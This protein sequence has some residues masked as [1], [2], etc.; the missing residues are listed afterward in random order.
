MPC[1]SN[2]ARL[3]SKYFEQLGN[4]F[5]DE[6]SAQLEGENVEAARFRDMN[7]G[8]EKPHC[9]VGAERPFCGKRT[10][11]KGETQQHNR[12]VQRK[13]PPGPLTG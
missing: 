5:E 2:T 9:Q 4:K 8:R 10:E 1:P 7:W 12:F 6:K 11:K 3:A 13:T